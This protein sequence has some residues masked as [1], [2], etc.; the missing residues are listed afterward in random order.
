MGDAQA[1]TDELA[2]LVEADEDWLVLPAEPG[3]VELAIRKGK[4][5]RAVSLRFKQDLP[6]A[7]ITKGLTSALQALRRKVTS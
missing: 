4:R 5:T 3:W 2:L 6:P 7:V 1:T